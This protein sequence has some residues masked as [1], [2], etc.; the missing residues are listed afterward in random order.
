MEA[1][2][3][4]MVAR[5]EALLF[6][7]GEP[8]AVSKIAKLLGVGE[9]ECPMLLDRFEQMLRDG[10][11]RGLMLVR[12]GAAVQLVTKSDFRE[13]GQKLI[14]EEFRE[15]LTPAALETLS[16]VGYL[17]PLPRST[18]DYIR[19]VN[20][21]FTL[22]NLM[23]RGLIE[24]ATEL[25]KGNMYCYRASMRFLA[26]MGL[27]AVEELPEY[28]RYRSVLG[29]LGAPAEGAPPV[30]PQPIQSPGAA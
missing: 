25:E 4:K 6:Y 2:D 21:S 29:R 14:E 3:A 18:I 19:G 28:E 23:V 30:E 10:S 1:S 13:I 26:H 8:I 17:G 24:R 5:L 16:I 7:H 9:G 22:R 11:D 27:A 15:E 20:S 12:N